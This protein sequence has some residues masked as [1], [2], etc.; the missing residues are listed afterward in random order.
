M[1]IQDR[2][3]PHIYMVLWTNKS[4]QELIEMNIIHTWFPEDSSSNGPIMHDLVNRLQLHKCNDNYCKRGDLTK[5]CRFG[6]SKPYFPVT[7]LDSEHRCTYKRDVGDVYVNNYSPYP[8][9]DF[10]T[11]MD[12]QYNGVR[13]LQIKI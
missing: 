8:L 4:V 11:S 9:D 5:K 7:F 2:G 6:Y 13:Y 10:R 12:V 3:S 1:E